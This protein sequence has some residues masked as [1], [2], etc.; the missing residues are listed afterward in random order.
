MT[1][2]EKCTEEIKLHLG[3]HLKVDLERLCAKAGQEALSPFIRQL[4]SE[5]VYG[6]LNPH[7]DLMAA[8]VRAE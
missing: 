2:K 1:R 7:G 5:V 8:S 6:K 3:P 4:L